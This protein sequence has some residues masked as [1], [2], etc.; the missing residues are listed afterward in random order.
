VEGG[1]LPPPLR[2]YLLYCTVRK[3]S[4]SSIGAS[5]H[6]LESLDPTTIYQSQFYEEDTSQHHE[7]QAEKRIHIHISDDSNRRCVY[8]YWY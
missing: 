7:F 1:I 2:L 8:I 3:A 6:E 4:S 5:V